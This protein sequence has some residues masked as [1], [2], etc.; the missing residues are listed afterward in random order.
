MR[1]QWNFSEIGEKGPERVQI[2]LRI[3][4]KTFVIQP[5]VL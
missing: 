3:P 1:P 5:V 2:D 4:Y